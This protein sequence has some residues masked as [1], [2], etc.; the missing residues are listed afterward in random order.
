MLFSE[1][2]EATKE[3]EERLVTIN[4][5]VKCLIDQ[6]AECR[7][8]TDMEEVNGAIRCELERFR[9][10]LTALRGLAA[11]LPAGSDAQ[12]ALWTDV[13]SHEKHLGDCTR[14]FKQANL[15]CIA[16]IDR[17][18]KEALFQSSS[19]AS[20]RSG[21][22]GGALRFR[23]S[24]S[25][26]SVVRES[27]AV[28]DHLASISRKLAAT[29]ERSAATVEELVQSSQTVD[30]TKEEFKGMGS[31][32]GQAKKLISKY[33]RRGVTDRVLILFA[34][35]FFF[36]CVFYVLRKRVLGP[37]DP[38]TLIWTTITTIFTYFMQ[39][40]GLID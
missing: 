10:A 17:R 3:A 36:A 14:S 23:P 27:G 25:R 32:I 13:R 8:Q 39:L 9:T 24:S 38:F 26:P 11:A 2:D 19:G 21:G 31:A 1:N 6:F 35:A 18:Q 20:A 16:A 4:L 34:V 7:T 15:R 12:D 29:V 22:G 30:D 5:R 37:L 40:F 28:T 33:G